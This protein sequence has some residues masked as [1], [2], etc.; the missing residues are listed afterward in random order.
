L[1]KKKI[2]KKDWQEKA[3]TRGKVQIREG[4]RKEVGIHLGKKRGNSVKKNCRVVRDW[5]SLGGDLRCLP[6]NREETVLPPR[7]N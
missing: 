5:N 1:V 6:K 3:S 4:S 2:Q 7:D